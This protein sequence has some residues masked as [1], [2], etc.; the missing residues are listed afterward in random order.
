MIS[1]VF[2]AAGPDGERGPRMVLNLRRQGCSGGTDAI[3]CDPEVFGAAR[4]GGL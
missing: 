2:A 1:A 4:D 3:H